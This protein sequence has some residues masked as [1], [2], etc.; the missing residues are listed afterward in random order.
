MLMNTKTMP[1]Q[2]K[3]ITMVYWT[4][5][6]NNIAGMQFKKT[7]KTNYAVVLE[8]S[9]NVCFP[10]FIN[11]IMSYFWIS[12]IVNF[13][14]SQEC[15]CQ[16]GYVM[17]HQMLSFLFVSDSLVENK[18]W[19]MDFH[20][21]QYQNEACANSQQV[22]PHDA[23]WNPTDDTACDDELCNSFASNCCDSNHGLHFVYNQMNN[24]WSHYTYS[25]IGANAAQQAQTICP[26]LPPI[27]NDRGQN[28]NHQVHAPMAHHNC[29]LH[30]PLNHMNPQMHYSTNQSFQNLLT[31]QP[32]TQ[33]P[34]QSFVGKKLQ[35]KKLKLAYLGCVEFPKLHLI[36]QYSKIS[37]L[38]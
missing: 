29:H 12:D 23:T 22:V 4:M 16:Q 25:N 24:H 32:I 7:T 38:P 33:L 37:A 30:Y 5:W 18:R 10:V 1:Q 36:P 28:W 31:T 3:N 15:L 11:F 13:Y 19:F 35:L 14:L 2:V 17:H 34:Q 9:Q 8:H 26:M 6:F 20:I 27:A 21:G